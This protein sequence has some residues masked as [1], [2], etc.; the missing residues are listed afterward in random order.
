MEA[1]HLPLPLVAC[2]SAGASSSSSSNGSISSGGSAQRKTTPIH[3]PFRS[4]GRGCQ[5]LSA[6]VHAG[7]KADPVWVLC[8]GKA[9][10][11]FAQI[12]SAPAEN[13][14]NVMLQPLHP[15][16]HDSALFRPWSGHLW[17][18]KKDK[19]HPVTMKREVIPSARIN[20][21]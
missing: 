16:P 3:A 2:S 8:A 1:V 19:L 18:A 10:T 9:Q 11:Y 14:S 17:M 5:A 6:A 15:S 13:T 4:G 21:P 7:D 20:A 12:M